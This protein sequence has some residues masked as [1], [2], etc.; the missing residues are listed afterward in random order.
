MGLRSAL[1]HS[2]YASPPAPAGS[3]GGGSDSSSATGSG[4]GS[5]A[6]TSSDYGYNYT[7]IPYTEVSGQCEQGDP[8][9]PGSQHKRHAGRCR[10]F[11]LS[12]M[13]LT[14]MPG[15]I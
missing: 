9:W 8:L 1:G 7:Y 2:P 11:S 15:L 5:G 12:Y 14:R 3:A 6:G 10:V 13:F 4:D